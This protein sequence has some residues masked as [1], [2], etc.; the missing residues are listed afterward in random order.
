MRISVVTATWNREGYLPEALDSI[1]AEGFEDL[2]AV[3]V[4]DGSTDSTPGVAARYGDRIRYLRQ[5]NAGPSAARNRGVEAACAPLVA[6][7]DSDDAWLPGRLARQVPMLESEPDAILLYAAVD[8]VD[9]DGRPVP[10]A[11]LPRRT[12]SG[13]ALAA[14]LRENFVRMPTVIVRRDAFLAAGGFR[15]DLVHCEDWDLWMRLAGK[16][17]FLYDP[18]PSAR[19]RLHG[20][21][22]IR[23]RRLLAEARVR[24]L[25]DHV[26]RLEAAG[27]PHLPGARR[28]LAHRCLRLARLDL[29]EGRK[30]EATRLMKRAVDLVPS[31]RLEAF[32]LRL[33]EGLRL[34]G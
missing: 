23:D 20:S 18:V 33:V 4:D 10:D 24:I 17:R 19:Y 6:F 21:Q 13:E 12:P 7:L 15:E 9:G 5:E 22:L 25:G 1:L 27:S 3:V 30:E 34:R 26:P 14:L 11:R 32:R 31:M 28:A 8:Y 29:R 2:E 16:G